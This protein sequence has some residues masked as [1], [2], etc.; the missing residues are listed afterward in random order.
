MSWKGEWTDENAQAIVDRARRAELP[1]P[2]GARQR[3]WR[4]LNRRPASRAWR[5][6]FPMFFAGATCAA[7]AALFLLRKP[8]EA[9]AVQFLDGGARASIRPGERLR[10]VGELSRVDLLSAGQ[11]VSGRGTQA[12]IERMDADGVSIRLERGSLLAHV[13]PRS[14]RAPF[15]VNTP[16]FAAH[17]V[18]T[19]LRV[20]VGPDGNASIAV[21]RGT[22]EVHTHSGERV[23]VRTGERWP[24]DSADLPEAAELDRLGA[25]E[26]EGVSAA[27]FAPPAPA[28][29]TDYD[30]IRAESALYE[31]GWT[32]WREFKDGS[33]A[34]SIWRKQRERFPRGTL[35][36]EVHTSIIDV[37]VALHR[38]SQARA[39]IESYLAGNPDAFR[40]HELRFVLGTL[41]RELDGNCRRAALQFAR[42]LERPATPWAS[43]AR[44]AQA[45]CGRPSRR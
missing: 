12:S 8:P 14:A 43:R 36:V 24:R 31:E 6:A 3:V 1:V 15:I 37:L 30:A 29:A 20:V 45:A 16:R 4:N 41:Y 10:S 2:A 25:A 40:A 18:G 27:S 17:V 7:L 11:M 22:V 28:H 19:V 21:G 23:T 35:R 38:S 33:R 9:I 34:L 26:L 44:A 13:R 5:L 32:A 42:A 39:E